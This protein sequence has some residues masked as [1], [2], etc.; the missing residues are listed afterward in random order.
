[1]EQLLFHIER[2]QLKWFRHYIRMPCWGLSLKVFWLFH[3]I[4]FPLQTVSDWINVRS[5]I[6]A[7]PFCN[8]G[9]RYCCAT[10]ETVTVR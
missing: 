6:N 9:D 1:M 10:P 3:S 8:P 2:S 7:D 5:I 4:F